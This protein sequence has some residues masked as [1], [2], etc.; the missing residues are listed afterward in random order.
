MRDIRIGAAQFEH[1]NAD[2]NYNLSAMKQLIALAVDRGAEILSFHE[3]CIPAYTFLRGSSKVQLLELA[4]TI[5]DGPSTRKLI[6]M[7]REFKIVILAGLLERDNR[8]NVYNAYI[9][10][11]GDGLIAKHR[12]LHAF[13]NEHLVNGNEY[14]VFQQSY[15]ECANYHAHGCRSHFHASCNLWSAISDAGSWIGR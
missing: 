5:P 15:R 4:E 11:N 12:K 13:I 1:R 8:K 9:C 3:A 7:A 2:K 6:E 10:V 14:C